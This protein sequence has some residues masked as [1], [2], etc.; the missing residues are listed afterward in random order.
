M[1][2]GPTPTV[3]PQ[4]PEFK[5]SRLK[6]VAYGMSVTTGG[7]GQVLFLGSVFGGTVLSYLAATGM[8]AFAE[9]VMAASGDAS[10]DHRVHHRA[11]KLML[12]LSLIVACYAGGN[13]IAHF[14]HNNKALAVMFAGASVAGFLL[15]ILDGHIRA[16]AY[17]R[18]LSAWE[19]A[20]RK[21]AAPVQ[22]SQTVR[23]Q[24]PV[25]RPEAK[26]VAVTP[27][28]PA[29][30]PSAAEPAAAVPQPRSLPAADP[31]N[32]TPI[33]KHGGLSQR[34]QAYQWFAAQIDAAGGDLSAVS[35]P[36]IAAQFDSD[37]LKKK[38]TEFKRRY[39]AEHPPAAVND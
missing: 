18:E 31:N 21:A 9:F 20:E 19:A 23:V 17:L 25:P 36:D 26:P 3:R 11:W 38:I 33:T 34:E 7:L 29:V 28:A 24:P 1:Y 4:P 32:V 8:A 5:L 27:P 35:G 10:L 39:E 37:H 15:H 14:W 2:P 22:P 30:K 13:Q 16:A 12:V 6:K